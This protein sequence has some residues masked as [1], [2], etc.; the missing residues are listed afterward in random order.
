ME[1]LAETNLLK[2]GA[3]LVGHFSRGN[4]GRPS[5]V[6]DIRP[7]APVGLLTLAAQYE[8]LC[9]R[10]S[11]AGSPAGRAGRLS[12]QWVRGLAMTC[13]ARSGCDV[14]RAAAKNA[15]LIVEFYELSAR[16]RHV[17]HRSRYRSVAAATSSNPNDVA[18]SS[19]ACYPGICHRRRQGGTKLGRNGGGPA[20]CCCRPPQ[21]RVSSQCS[22][23]W[24]S[25]FAAG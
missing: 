24:C 20:G 7:R 15:I 13:T 11:S 25:R 22:T 18:G 3:T 19:S 4:Q 2:E 9:C 17:G 10:S 12:A 6:P 1:R 16:K 8:S 23:S 5:V 21:H 14:D